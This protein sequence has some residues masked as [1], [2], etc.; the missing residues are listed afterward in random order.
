MS[1]VPRKFS[2]TGRLK[3]KINVTMTELAFPDIS[4]GICFPKESIKQ[5][6]KGYVPTDILSAES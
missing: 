6:G 1:T 2:L 4:K 5:R 3:G